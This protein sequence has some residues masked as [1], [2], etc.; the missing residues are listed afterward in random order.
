MKTP[1]PF[2]EHLFEL[3]ETLSVEPKLKYVI[4]QDTSNH[5]WRVQGV[6]V[7]NASF[8]LR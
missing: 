6:P 1:A 2:K 7:Q 5:T 4:F 3:E 8:V